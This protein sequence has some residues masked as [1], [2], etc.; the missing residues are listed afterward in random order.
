VG[1]G[2]NPGGWRN[3]ERTRKIVDY[4][5]DKILYPLV[6][7]CRTASDRDKLVL[8]GQPTDSCLQIFW[9]YGLF[10]E[11]YSSDFVVKVSY[12]LDEIFVSLVDRLFMLFGNFGH[13][14]S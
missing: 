4:S 11:E 6:L 8:D 10:F 12:L 13:L 14:V 3:I 1:V 5:I 7:K 2:V 9:R